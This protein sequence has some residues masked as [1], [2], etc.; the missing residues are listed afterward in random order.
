MSLLLGPTPHTQPCRKL[1]CFQLVCSLEE[2]SGWLKSSL[3]A[4][5]R[6]SG[7]S[8]DTRGRPEGALNCPWVLEAASQVPAPPTLGAG[9]RSSS[10]GRHLREDLRLFLKPVFP[11]KLEVRVCMR[12][13][14]KASASGSYAGLGQLPRCAGFY[15]PSR[16][17][18]HP[19][20]GCRCH[21][22]FTCSRNAGSSLSPA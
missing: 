17:S 7:R 2:D 12:R 22:G 18:A 5:G 16:A 13:G 19:G 15:P 9:L 1:H 6:G 8:P 14:P 11:T 10:G 4:A 21:A 3:V 20:K